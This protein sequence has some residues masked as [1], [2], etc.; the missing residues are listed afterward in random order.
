MREAL[1]TSIPSEHLHFP[2]SHYT[3]LEDPL[4]HHYPLSHPRITTAACLLGNIKTPSS[5]TGVYGTAA[6]PTSGAGWVGSRYCWAINLSGVEK[7]HMLRMRESV[8]MPIGRAEN[9]VHLRE[10]LRSGVL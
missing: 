5:L 4:A 6:A 3:V 2:P 7:E 1:E 10:L 9:N 8:T